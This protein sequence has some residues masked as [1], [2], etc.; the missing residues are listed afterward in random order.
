MSVAAALPQ[1]R[2]QRRDSGAACAL[3]FPELSSRAGNVA[4]SFGG[5]VSLSRIRRKISH[6]GMD[7]RLIQRRAEHSLGQFNLTNLFVL[8]V[9]HLDR[10][11]NHSVHSLF[12][13]AAVRL[14]ISDSQFPIPN[15]RFPIPDFPIFRFPI[16]D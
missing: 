10:G 4:T 8:Y 13:T 11:H 3:L 5:R 9:A 6:G 16:S 12:P 7:Q 14:P 15:S 2:A 1:W